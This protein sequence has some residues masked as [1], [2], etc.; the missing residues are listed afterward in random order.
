MTTANGPFMRMN[1]AACL[2][3]LCLATPLAGCQTLGAEGAVALAPS[4]AA[5]PGAEPIRLGKEQFR[6]G[7]F[8]L[9]EATFRIAVERVP[10]NAEA[11]L[12]LAAAH[13]RLARFD[14]ADREYA[15]VEKLSGPSLALTNNRGYSM[16]LRGNLV[17]ARKYLTEAATMAPDDEDVKINLIALRKAAGRR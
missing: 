14:L 5:D 15:Q 4:V 3:A 17:A 7:N 16:L 1:K 11:W 8:G 12:G 13:D 10:N 9:A 2:F 6:A